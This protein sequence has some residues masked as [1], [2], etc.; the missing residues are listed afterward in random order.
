MDVVILTKEKFTKSSIG[1]RR[2]EKV[3]KFR[4]FQNFSFYVTFSFGT[5]DIIPILD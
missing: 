4:T 3:L 1:P 2:I 5:Y